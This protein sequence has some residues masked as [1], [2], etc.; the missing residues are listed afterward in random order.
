L[1]PNQSGSLDFQNVFSA[2]TEQI[3]SGF[4]TSPHFRAAELF[5]YSFPTAHAY[6]WGLAKGTFCI[7]Y[8]EQYSMYRKMS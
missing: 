2:H 4:H 6:L 7:L 1:L 5:F 3:T 8:W